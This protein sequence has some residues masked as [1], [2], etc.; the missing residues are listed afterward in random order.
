LETAPGGITTSYTYD[1]L[2]RITKTTQNI[3]EHNFVFSYKYDNFGNL[4]EETYPS[5]F[6]IENMY[7]QRGFLTQVNNK[8]TSQPIWELLDV[9]SKGQPLELSL[10]NG[11]HSYHE[12]DP[13]GF[14][15]RIGT[16]TYPSYTYD[17]QDYLYHFIPEWGRPEQRFNLFGNHEYFYYDEDGSKLNRLS[18]V[19]VP[20]HPAENL[21]MQY[22]LNGN[23]YS[24][25]GLGTYAYEDPQHLHAVTKVDNTAPLIP[26]IRQDITYT[27]FNKVSSIIEGE[28]ELFFTY[29][30]ANQRVKTEYYDNDIQ[31][32]KYFAGNYEQVIINGNIRELHYIAGPMGLAAIYVKNNGT[33]SMYY[34]HTDHLGS[35]TEITD[36]TG[37]LLQRMQYDAWGKRSF[38]TNNI[39]INNFLFDRGYTG[40]E[41]LDQFALINMN[42]RLYDPILGRMLSPDNFAQSSTQG[43]NRYSYA[44]NNPMVYVDPDGNFPWAFVAGTALNMAL[45]GYQMYQAYEKAGKDPTTGALV[46][47]GIGLGTS[48]LGA[49]GPSI[50]ITGTLPGA[51]WGAVSGGAT[52]GITSW[53]LTKDFW[54]GAKAGGLSG[55]LMGGVSGYN[56]AQEQGRNPWSGSEMT[57]DQN[58]CLNPHAQA[59][60]S[61]ECQLASFEA[62]DEFHGGRTIDFIKEN[63]GLYENGSWDTDIQDWGHDY[64]EVKNRSDAYHFM[65]KTGFGG[66]A[67]INANWSKM[68]HST[69][70]NEIQ[71]WRSGFFNIK[72]YKMFVMDPDPS[73]IQNYGAYRPLNLPSNQVDYLMITG[74][75]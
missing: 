4:K 19:T 72:Y 57:G 63:S 28:N 5:G 52:G 2:G 48:L 7:N 73:M 23:I 64:T 17:V 40:H 61:A 68:G 12:Y 36:N 16:L 39:G 1:N 54:S 22:S 27:P 71:E 50:G 51:A 59:P 34:T 33:D 32:T 10:G 75:H 69:A 41:H 47:A 15:Y 55:G 3:P 46:G 24:K 60:G 53:V 26:D 62:N 31:K 42:G 43:L 25:T 66:Y 49:L 14:L 20:M 11:L 35:I 21:S 58:V 44:M 37:T 8:Q 13:Y 29:G 38:I 9:N 74:F 45:S 65:Q 18:R 56:S 67:Q 30:T 6:T 70:I